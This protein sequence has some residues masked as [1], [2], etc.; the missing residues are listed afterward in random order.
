VIPDFLPTGL[1]PPG[2]HEAPW[3]EIRDRFGGNFR[4]NDILGGIRL[5][6]LNL[7]Q[8]GCRRL[9]IDGSFVTQKRAPS[10]WDGCWDPVGVDPAKL[11]GIIKDPTP[12]GRARMKQKYKADLF[13]SSVLEQ[14]SRL[15]FVDFFQVDKTTGDPKG[16]L[17]LD[18]TRWQP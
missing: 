11:D 2:E 17:L 1:L 5:A 8:A 10:D 13:P 12:L 15:L 14:R 6:A 4:R 7:K 9:W 16:I 3:E 18:L